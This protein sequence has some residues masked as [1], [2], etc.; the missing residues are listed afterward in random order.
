MSWT[1][2]E[3]SFHDTQRLLFKLAERVK[4]FN[5]LTTNEISEL[6]ETAEKC[7]YQPQ[8]NI[9]SEG[10]VGMYMYVIIDGDAVVT[11]KGRDGDTELARLGPADS[12]GEMALTDRE[13]RSATVTACTPCTLIRIS[14]KAIDSQPTIGLKVF[15]NISRVLS[16]RLRN[17]DEL[18]VWRL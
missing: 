18:L 4:A 14:E 2:Q 17:A 1:K 8:Q 7:V 16:E 10:A 11:K 6:L 13:S 9:I 3:F 15:R 12:F 5:G